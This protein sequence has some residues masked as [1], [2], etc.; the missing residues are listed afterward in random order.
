MEPVHLLLAL[1]VVGGVFGAWTAQRAGYGPGQFA[2]L[3][4]LAAAA[5]ATIAWILV[6]VLEMGSPAG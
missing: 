1:V 5:S 3:V 2:A 6:I 4:A